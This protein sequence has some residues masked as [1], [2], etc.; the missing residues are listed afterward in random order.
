MKFIQKRISLKLFL[1][2]FVVLIVGAAVLLFTVM[3]TAQGAY[4]RHMEMNTTGIINNGTRVPEMMGMGQGRGTGSGT[5]QGAGLGPG[6]GDG[7]INFRAG[8]LE[9]LGYAIIAAILVAVMVSIIFSQQIIAPLR[10]MMSAS[11]RIADGRYDER[12]AVSGTDELAQLAERFNRMAERLEHTESM[13]RQLIGDVSHELRTPLT[14][15]GGYMEGLTDGVLPA[16]AETF[17]QVKMESKRLSRLVDD[18]QELSR[19]ESGAYRLN[20]QPVSLVDLLNTTARRLSFQ[21]TEKHVLLHLPYGSSES[22]HSDLPKVMVDE[23]RITQVMTN[24]LANALIYTQP[25]GDVTVSMEQSGNEIQISFTDT[26]VGISPENCEHIFDRF[27]R[28]DKSRSRAGGGGSGI[29]LTIARAIVD[30]HG[31]RIWAQSDGEGLG[32]KF[33]FTVPI[34]K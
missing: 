18:L 27:Y 21:F 30:A 10:A 13:R 31:G 11:Q 4:S 34:S 16:S 8:V 6:Q 22:T 23:D 24:L 7:Y 33:I 28:V 17:E 2:Y 1:S 15:I 12:V 32:S 20:I 9:S 19:V 3:F 25:G 26:G 5:G 14:A 29:G